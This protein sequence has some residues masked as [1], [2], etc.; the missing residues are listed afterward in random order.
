MIET[1][2]KLNA[3]DYLGYPDLVLCNGAVVS[4]FYYEM[5]MPVPYGADYAD[6][7]LVSEVVLFEYVPPR[8]VCLVRYHKFDDLP[9]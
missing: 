2:L 1:K 9:F 3:E 4:F 5:Y 7:E 6:V 8:H